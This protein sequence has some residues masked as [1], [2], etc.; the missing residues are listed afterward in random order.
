[1]IV[2]CAVCCVDDRGYVRLRAGGS[3]KTRVTARPGVLHTRSEELNTGQNV[4]TRARAARNLV[5]TRSRVCL[6]GCSSRLTETLAILWRV[7]LSSGS[8]QLQ[9]TAELC[10]TQVCARAALE[11]HPLAYI[12]VDLPGRARDPVRI[13]IRSV[14]ALHVTC[15][16][17]A[18]PPR[19]T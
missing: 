14:H 7:F 2:L 19:R 16:P 13:S 8:A 18:A 6:N 3:C 9:R 1:M 17:D 5:G 4:Q 12:Q 10:C 11:R 15:R